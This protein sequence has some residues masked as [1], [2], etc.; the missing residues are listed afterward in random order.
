MLLVE[1]A[2][3]AEYRELVVAE[4]RDLPGQP[5]DQYVDQV[6]GAEALSGAVDAGQEL[7]CDDLAVQHFRWIEAVVAIAAA[8]LVQLLAEIG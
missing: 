8:A 6:H 3:D 1:L 4:L 7:L 2:A 5:A